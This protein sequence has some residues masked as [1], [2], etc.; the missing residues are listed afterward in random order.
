MEVRY[1]SIP[2]KTRVF[3]R[4]CLYLS[5]MH[6]L[7]ADC[8]LGCNLWLFFT[9]LPIFV[10][11]PSL[12]SYLYFFLVVFLPLCS[13]LEFSFPLSPPPLSS[14]HGGLCYVLPFPFLLLPHVGI[15]SSALPFPAVLLCK[16]THYI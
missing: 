12:M 11:S 15:S 13:L 16:P 6:S 4:H 5:Y 2:L 8:Q 3:S 10:P 7:A 9:L 14:F 1:W